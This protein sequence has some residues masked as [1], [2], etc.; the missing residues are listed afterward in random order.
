MLRLVGIS[1]TQLSS[2]PD[3]QQ[4]LHPPI[5]ILRGSETLQEDYYR[6]SNI[7][8]DHYYPC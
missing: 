7:P 6:C 3:G 5:L 4:R 2:F 1:S 8:Q